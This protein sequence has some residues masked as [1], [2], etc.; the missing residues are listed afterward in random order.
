MKNT[1][2]IAQRELRAYFDSLVAY[3]VVGLSMIGLGAYF[4]LYRGGVW[5]VDR[6]SIGLM[7]EFLPWILTI[8]VIPLVTMRAIAEEKRSGTFELLITLPVTDSEVILGKYLGALGM[9]F[10]LL[11]MT[12]LYPVVMFVWPW[13]L[14]ALDWGPVWSGYLGLSLFCAAGVA[15]GLLFSSLTE[16]QVIAF[17][18]TAALLG[19]LYAIGGLTEGTRSVFGDVIAFTSFQSR[20]I[21]FSRGLIDTRAIVYFLSITVLCLLIAF[22]SLESRKWS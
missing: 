12:F 3:V 19:F 13:H 22:R 15:V 2:T 11:A 14:G 20:F 1:F 5:Q 18:F 16:S 17:F 8:I 21:P 9:T 4:F 7:F 10:V 6:A